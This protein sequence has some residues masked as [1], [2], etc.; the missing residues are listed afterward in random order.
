[1]RIR[2]LK[3]EGIPA[4]PPQWWFSDERAGEEGIL[5]NVQFRYDQTPACLLIVATHLSDD[6][7]GIII[8][9][10]F[11]H[12]EILCQKLKKTLAGR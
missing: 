7:I 8:L 2:D 3:W 5:K 9:E 11:A 12:L 1:M 6:R 4:W 10:N